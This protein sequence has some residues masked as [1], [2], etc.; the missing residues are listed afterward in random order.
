MGVRFFLLMV[1]MFVIKSLILFAAWNYA[2]VDMMT[3]L[4]P[5]TVGQAFAAMLG[6]M[7]LT[8]SFSYKES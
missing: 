6:W 7:L 8:F 4:K 3:I 1:V 2:F 5:I